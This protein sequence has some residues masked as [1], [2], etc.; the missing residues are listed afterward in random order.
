MLQSAIE[1]VFQH[2]YL[3]GRSATWIPEDRDP[4]DWMFQHLYLL[5]RSATGIDLTVDANEIITF[6]HLYLLRR[7]AT[8][9]LR[10]VENNFHSVSTP[11]PSEKVCDT[12]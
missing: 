4:E 11:L 10:A 9:L 6:Q 5:R 1:S 12:E 8:L 2:L 7:S 3:L